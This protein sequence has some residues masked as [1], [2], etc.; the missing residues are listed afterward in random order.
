MKYDTIA[1]IYSAN[2]KI[3]IGLERTVGGL[4][5]HEATALPA[6]EK[7]SI[8][9]IV[10]H[11]SIVDFSTYRICSKLLAAV[12]ADGKPSHG[13]VTLHDMLSAKF[14]AV[15]DVK[16]EAP[17]RVHPTGDLTIH[18]SL[19][20]M[21]ETSKGFAE[22][23]PNLERFDFDDHKFPHPYFG[24]MTA[25]EWMIV[26]GGHELRHTRQIEKLLEKIR[27]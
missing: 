27:A 12:E 5:G 1:D 23:R 16:L 11:V 22:L 15:S 6:D 10:E 24:E 8:Q 19:T 26:A 4:A 13:R 2:Q 3:R 7:W 21:R 14:D 17:E 9:Q 20:K 18:D 25:A